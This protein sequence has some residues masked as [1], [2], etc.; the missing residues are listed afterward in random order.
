MISGALPQSSILGNSKGF[1]L[2][3]VIMLV[4]IM[5]I[6]LTAIGQSWKTLMQREREEE[7]LFRG[8]QFRDAIKRWYTPLPGQQ[9]ATPLRDIKDL[10]QDPRTATHVKYLRRYYSDPMTG[11]EWRTISDPNIGITGV[12]STSQEKPFKM[13][14]FPDEIQ[15]F[16]GKTRYCDWEF[17]I[18]KQ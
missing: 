6:M 3:A 4:I 17:D 5:G 8:L 16:S 13:D 2:M 7:L 1:T 15:S 12:A 10:L 11:R 14:N 9:V 18:R